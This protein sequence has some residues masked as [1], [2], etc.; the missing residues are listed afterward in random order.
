LR[1]AG[2]DFAFLVITLP[3]DI[4]ASLSEYILSPSQVKK[5]V[6]IAAAIG[7]TEMIHLRAWPFVLKL[8][9]IQYSKT[10]LAILS[11]KL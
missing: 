9:T 2:I 1:A 11:R 8:A 4:L 6:P 7:T 10:P 5:V 3:T